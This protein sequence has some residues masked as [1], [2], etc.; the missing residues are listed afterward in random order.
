M[1]AAAT[2]PAQI[3]NLL[4]AIAAKQTV[5][6]SSLQLVQ[7]ARAAGLVSVDGWDLALTPAGEAAL[8]ASWGM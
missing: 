6:S 8:K 1:N 3:V 2:Q 4:T 5:P 7:Q